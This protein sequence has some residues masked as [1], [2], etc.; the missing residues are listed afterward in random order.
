MIDAARGEPGMRPSHIEAAAQSYYKRPGMHPGVILELARL[1]R[2]IAPDGVDAR[3]ERSVRENLD[4]AA[5]RL[6]AV[7]PLPPRPAPGSSLPPGSIPGL[8]FGKASTQANLHHEVYKR[9]AESR[10]GTP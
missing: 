9:L 10:R 1:A 3:T 5:A 7:P 8:G 4:M 6:P 2:S